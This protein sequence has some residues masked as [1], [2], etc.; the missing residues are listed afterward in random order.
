LS[1]MDAAAW[2]VT[3]W[4]Q[5]GGPERFPRCLESA[6]AWALP[7]AVVK[8]PR[9]G[10]TELREWLAERGIP[11]RLNATER[12]LRACVLARAGCGVVFVDGTDAEDELRLSLAHEVSH[13]VCDYLEPRARAL[14]ALGDGARDILDGV[15]A[16]TPAE[17][18]TGLFAGIE[19]GGAYARLMERAPTGDVARLDILDAEDRAD[20]LALE[21]LAPRATVLARLE[22]K[23]VEWHAPSAVDVASNV[24]TRD[25]GLPGSA[26]TQYGRMLVMSQRPA[27]NFRDWL[28]A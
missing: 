14:A 15:R 23:G 17:R 6:V 26:A 28:G 27:R 10:L 21:L 22:S 16:P 3:F 18:L 12:R 11:F 8:L 7:V 1:D 25:F 19:L 20:R 4:R 9:L 2:A 13:F 5:A 24:L